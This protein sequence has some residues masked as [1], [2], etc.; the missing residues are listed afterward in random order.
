MC[1]LKRLSEQDLDQLGQAIKEN[2]EISISI[3]KQGSDV[4]VHCN[5]ANPFNTAYAL[6][7]LNKHVKEQAE[8]EPFV[9]EVVNDYINEFFEINEKN[10]INKKV[11]RK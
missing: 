2:I 7:I 11:K 3:K 6:N 8:V 5:N 9:D 10:V 1:K 4:V